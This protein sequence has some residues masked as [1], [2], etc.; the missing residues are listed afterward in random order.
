MV[1]Q[2]ASAGTST[3]ARARRSRLA[4]E[5]VLSACTVLASRLLQSDAQVAGLT[6]STRVQTRSVAGRARTAEE[7]HAMSLANLQGEYATVLSQEQLL[8]AEIGPG[9]R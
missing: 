2:I 3:V 7:V 4:G 6:C 8:A 5:Q 9:C 1:L